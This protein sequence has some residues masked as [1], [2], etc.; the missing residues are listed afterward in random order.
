VQKIAR[1]KAKQQS[2]TPA[3]AEAKAEVT[4]AY[5]ASMSAL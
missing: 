1:T 3:Q 2:L 4:D 5:L